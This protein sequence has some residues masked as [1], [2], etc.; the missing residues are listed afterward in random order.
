MEVFAKFGVEVTV[1]E[2]RQFMGVAKK[3]HLRGICSL[4]SVVDQWQKKNGRSPDKTDVEGLFAEIEP[5]LIATV[6]NMAET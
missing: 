3:D 1:V 4:P 5:M 6:G 2:V